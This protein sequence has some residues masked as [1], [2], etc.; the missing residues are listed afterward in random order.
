MLE[1]SEKFATQA[2]GAADEAS[3]AD[4]RRAWKSPQVIVGTLEQAEAGGAG[5]SDGVTLS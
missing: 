2:P 3:A 5:N 4:S 1:Q